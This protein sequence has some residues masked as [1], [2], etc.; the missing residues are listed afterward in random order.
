MRFKNNGVIITGGASGIGAASARRFVNEGA[1]VAICDIN[2]QLGQALVMELGAS[3]CQYYHCD[4]S[5]I[6]QVANFINTANKWFISVG[7]SL[8]TL[9]NNAGVGGR[10]EA[11][12]IE[13]EQWHKVIGIDLNS[14]F[15][16]CR[17]AIPI[18]QEQD[19]GNIINTASV[20]GL[21]GDRGFGPY[22]AAKAAVINY[23]RTLAIDHGKD[24]IRV[25]AICPGLIDTP[26]VGGMDKVPPAFKAEYLSG[27]SLGRAGLGEEV[28]GVAA[29]LASDDAAYITGAS[30]VVDG[31]MSASNGNPNIEEWMHRT[32]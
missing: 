28:A 25:N 18:L 1:Y 3:H 21:L 31:G 12:K 5:D 23:T 16:A 22:N 2:E 29:F 13:V 30:I 8:C 32:Q 10:G 11:A 9:F 19:G 24:N 7:S 6:D 4:V 20:S 17:Y 27:I 26:L 15:Y 14:V